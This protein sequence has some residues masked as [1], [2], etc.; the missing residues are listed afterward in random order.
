M[1][2]KLDGEDLGVHCKFVKMVSDNDRDEAVH[3]ALKLG[4]PRDGEHLPFGVL[5]RWVKFKK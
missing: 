4:L 1:D 3:W 2:A 5:T